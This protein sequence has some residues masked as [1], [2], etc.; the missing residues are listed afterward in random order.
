MVS[1]YTVKTVCVVRR[2][3][4]NDLTFRTKLRTYSIKRQKVPKTFP[5][6]FK[7]IL[8]DPLGILFLFS[9]MS[10][11]VLQK[12]NESTLQQHPTQHQLDQIQYIIECRYHFKLKEKMNKIKIKLKFWCSVTFMFPEVKYMYL[13]VQN[14]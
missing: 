12:L 9:L 2:R 6:R 3:R 5:K 13:N 7:R 11:P 14:L 4:P 10:S 1:I 8:L